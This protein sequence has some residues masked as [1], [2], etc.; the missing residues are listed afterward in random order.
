M[1]G[2]YE[3]IKC[4]TAV[5]SGLDKVIRKACFEQVMSRERGSNICNNSTMVEICIRS[6]F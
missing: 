1:E 3:L 4:W 2:S 5:G 6:H